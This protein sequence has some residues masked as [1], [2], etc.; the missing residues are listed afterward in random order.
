MGPCARRRSAGGAGGDHG[1]RG[2][3]AAAAHHAGAGEGDDVGAR[4]RRSQPRT[5]R[6]AGGQGEARRAAAGAMSALAAIDVAVEDVSVSTGTVP[7]DAPEADGT[8]AWEATTIVVV[9]AC[10]GG[11]RG[12]G[13]TYADRSAARLVEGTLA[14]VVRGADALAPQRAWWAMARAVRNLGRDGIAA[15]AISAVDVALWDLK[16]RLLG[17]PLA[18]LLGASSCAQATR[19]TSN[20][21]RDPQPAPRPRAAAAVR[22]HRRRRVPAGRRDLPQPLRRL[23]RQQVDV[24]PGRPLTG[25]GRRRRRGRRVPARRPHVAA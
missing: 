12:I 24:G 21:E 17:L 7:T 20:G 19:R 2:A 25:R 8:F 13:Y 3:A 6:R 4:A 5:G 23:V 22:R 16:A 10:G 18:T 15:T 11:E 9:Q 1:P 14:Q